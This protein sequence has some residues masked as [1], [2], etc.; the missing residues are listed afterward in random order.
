MCYV[1][2]DKL[3]TQRSMILKYCSFVK[4]DFFL[5]TLGIHLHTFFQINQFEFI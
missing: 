5:F 1:S 2:I 3:Q 4:T